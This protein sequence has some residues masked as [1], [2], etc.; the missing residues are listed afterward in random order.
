MD[1][2]GGT[3]ARVLAG[4]LIELADGRRVRY[5]GVV[6]PQPGE[7][8]FEESRGANQEMV[9]GREVELAVDP[10]IGSSPDG[11]IVAHVYVPAR[12][13]PGGAEGGYVFANHAMVA[14]GSARAS[15][16]PERYKFR[17]MLL[18]AEAKARERAIGIWQAGGP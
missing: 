13:F 3:V 16:L 11:A 2:D 18:Q 10:A 12:Q 15:S 14:S 9:G 5:L 17:F 6:A 4:D 7:R 8:W 1:R